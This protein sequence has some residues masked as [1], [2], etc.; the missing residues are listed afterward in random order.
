MTPEDAVR[1]SYFEVELPS[2]IS[3]DMPAHRDDPDGISLGDLIPDTGPNPEDVLLNKDI[4]RQV[5]EEFAKMRENERRA[6]VLHAQGYTLEEIGQRMG[7]CRERVRQWESDGRRV[8]RGETRYQCTPEYQ[9]AEK[10]R[11]RAARE[12]Y[13][14][15]DEHRRREVERNRE[16]L[17]KKREGR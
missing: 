2:V 6:I 14:K 12:K 4:R 10:R 7:V 13:M 9:A 1:R 16:S 8:A 17:R 11:R 5:A 3:L 15:D